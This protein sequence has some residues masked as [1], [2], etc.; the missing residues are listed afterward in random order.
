MISYLLKDQSIQGEFIQVSYRSSAALLGIAL[1]QNIYG[2]SGMAPL[3]IVGSVPLYNI[4]AVVVLSFFTPERKGLNKEVLLK[5]W[6]L[7]CPGHGNMKRKLETLKKELA[8]ILTPEE[9]E[10]IDEDIS[11][12]YTNLTLDGRFV[13]VGDNKWNLR[14]RVKFEN[15]VKAIVSAREIIRS[16]D[17]S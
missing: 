17:K 6:H 9:M 14:E 11:F 16:I 10:N 2:T 8:K 1:I 5:T 7:L 13:N 15:G 3:M 12:F 4:M